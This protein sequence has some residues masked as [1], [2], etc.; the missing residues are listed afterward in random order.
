MTHLPEMPPG[1]RLVLVDFPDCIYLPY[2][3]I[4]LIGNKY[5]VLVYRNALPFHLDSPLSK[6]NFKP[7]LSQNIAFK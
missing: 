6:I 4:R 3:V 5:R 1:A 7:H 2:M